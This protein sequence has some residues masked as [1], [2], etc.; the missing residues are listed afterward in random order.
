[1]LASHHFIRSS[2]FQLANAAPTNVTPA[3]TVPAMSNAS[4]IQFIPWKTRELKKPSGS[5]KATSGGKISGSISKGKGKGKGRVES[6]EV[7]NPA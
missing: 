5:S 2:V 1:M 7:M 3:S 4:G 6:T